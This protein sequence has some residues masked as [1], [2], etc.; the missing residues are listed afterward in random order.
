MIDDVKTLGSENFWKWDG[1]LTEEN[2]EAV[3]ERIKR[4]FLNR[5]HTWVEVT[6]MGLFKP[7][8]FTGCELEDVKV[9][10]TNDKVPYEIMLDSSRGWLDC[11]ST[12]VPDRPAAMRIHAGD[13]AGERAKLSR[14]TIDSTSLRIERLYEPR[15]DR[16]RE[17]GQYL[18]R[19][20]ALEGGARSE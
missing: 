20:L 18:T 11:I 1:F 15:E 7:K 10:Y 4:N 2:A 13:D 3:A 8:V 16:P 12:H 19:V 17:V 9:V 14:L 6:R 5:P